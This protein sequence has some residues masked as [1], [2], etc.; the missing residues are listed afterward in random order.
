MIYSILYYFQFDRLLEYYDNN[1]DKLTP[2]YSVFIHEEIHDRFDA[3]INFPSLTIQPNQSSFLK[4]R[5]S[6]I[7][8]ISS[9][10]SLCINEPY[11]GPRRCAIMKVIILFNEKS[12]KIIHGFFL[13]RQEKRYLKSINAD[14]SI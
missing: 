4:L 14:Y 13:F 9:E 8:S 7:S 6:N 2:E 11:Y 12:T 1:E 10:Q 3:P 5:K